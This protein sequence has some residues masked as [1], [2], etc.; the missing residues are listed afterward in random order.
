MAHNYVPVMNI[1]YVYAY[2]YF[3]LSVRIINIVLVLMIIKTDIN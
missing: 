1:D 3:G 2:T